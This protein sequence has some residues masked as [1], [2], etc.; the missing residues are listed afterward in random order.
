MQVLAEKGIDIFNTDKQ[1]NNVLHTAARYA[2]RFNIL[3]MLLKSRFPTDLRNASGD[4]A[5]HIAA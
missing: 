1:G 2:E 4:T 5:L 3:D